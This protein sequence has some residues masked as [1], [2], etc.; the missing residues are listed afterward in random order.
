MPTN[1][2]IAPDATAS[3]SLRARELRRRWDEYLSEGR[4]NQVR[5]PIADSW[6]RC[7]VAGIDPSR[8]RAPTLA[9]RREIGERWEAHPLEGAAPLIRRW[10]GPF[11][12]DGEHLTVVS[13]ADGLLL[14][15]DG[16]AK[17]RSAA[18]DAMNFV[19]GALWSEAGAGTNAIGTALAADHRCRSTPLSTSARSC[20]GEHAP[21]RLCTIPKTVGCSDS[22]TSPR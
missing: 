22:S 6:H 8:S 5:W 19:E 14:W 3:P 4:L 2:W 13:D 1:P 12:D 11:A 15:L 17:V 16:N 10:L 21:P 7:E 20:T 9:A 18:A